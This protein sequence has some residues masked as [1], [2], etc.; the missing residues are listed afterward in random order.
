MNVLDWID[1][2]C[3]FD[4]HKICHS[5][6]TLF[7]QISR[8]LSPNTTFFRKIAPSKFANLGISAPL[9]LDETLSP[10]VYCRLH[11]LA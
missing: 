8:P 9:S 3:C 7:I 2:D 1:V 4:H 10:P 6:L 5:F 11:L